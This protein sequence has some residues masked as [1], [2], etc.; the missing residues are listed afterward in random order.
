MINEMEALNLSITDTWT[1][2]SELVEFDKDVLLDS[3]VIKAGT[4]EP[5]YTDPYFLQR[6]SAAWWEKWRY[7]FQH[8]WTAAEKEYEPLWDR[9]GWEEID[10]ETT[11]AGTSGQTTVNKEVMDDDTTRTTHATE[12]VDDDTT[13]SSTSTGSITSNTTNKVSAYDAGNTLT[14]HDSSDTT[15]STTTSNTGAGTDDRTTTTDVSET[16]TDDRTTTF[17]GQVDGVTN[18]KRVYGH[19]LHSWGNWGI[20]QT[21][22]KLLASEFGVRYVTNPYD[23][24]SEIFC[25]E[26]CVRVF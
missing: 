7:T 5:I 22:Q 15:T 18:N 20:S 8:W 24:M 6:M 10:D 26:L 9:E 14:T 17:N 3:I 11:D 21:A 13:N 12:I 2:D 19:K 23:L 16:G 25:R 1:L 4:F